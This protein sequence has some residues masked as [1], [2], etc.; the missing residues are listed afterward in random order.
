MTNTINSINDVP[1]Y[2]ANVWGGFIWIDG[3]GQEQ[4][5]SKRATKEQCESTVLEACNRLG[6]E[7]AFA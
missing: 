3:D 5:W 6:V 4:R 7:A 1:G 2:A